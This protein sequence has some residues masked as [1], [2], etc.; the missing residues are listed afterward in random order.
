MK[1]LIFAVAGL[2]AAVGYGVESANIVGYQTQ[3][4]AGTGFAMK[5]ASFTSVGAT[6]GSS[7]LADIKIGGYEAYDEDTDEG[8]TTGDFSIQFL[9]GSGKTTATYRWIDDDTETGWKYNGSIIDASTVALPSGGAV[10]TKGAGLT[11]TSAGAVS[12]ADTVVKTEPTGFQAVGNTTPVDVTLADLAVTGYD[13]YDEDTDEGGT[14]GD[15]SIQVLNAQGKTTATYRWIDDD[16]ETGWKY[17]GDIID[18]TTVTIPAGTGVWVKG[19][20]LTLTIPSAIP[21]AD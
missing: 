5:S 19:S 20:G 10:W 11:M 7:T 2:C 14:T 17:N 16:T 6:D 13:P 8:G 15:F 21:A 3:N 9:N 1:K 18:A 12:D 4:T